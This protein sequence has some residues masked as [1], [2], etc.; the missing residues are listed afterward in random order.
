MAETGLQLETPHLLHSLWDAAVIWRWHL[1]QCSIT[2]VSLVQNFL[3][4]ISVL[5]KLFAEDFIL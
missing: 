1:P 2:P 3:S 5:I 4:V